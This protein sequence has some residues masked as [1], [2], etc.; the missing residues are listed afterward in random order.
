M[1]KCA[2]FDPR[3]LPAHSVWLKFNDLKQN[4]SQTNNN[5]RLLCRY[6]LTM[7]NYL[8]FLHEKCIGKVLAIGIRV[9][10]ISI[11]KR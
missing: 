2:K 5:V 6:R 8:K 3:V 4:N 9:Y 1:K 11:L 7:C 10:M